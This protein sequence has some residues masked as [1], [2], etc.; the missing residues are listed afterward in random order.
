MTAQLPSILDLAR[1][2]SDRGATTGL[3]R[4]FAKAVVKSHAAL[5]QLLHECLQAGFGVA[6][7][8]NWP[9]SIEDACA[10]IAEVETV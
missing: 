10:A 9:K 1:E 7:D 4:T 2:Y 8:Y 5:Q 3:E 6:N